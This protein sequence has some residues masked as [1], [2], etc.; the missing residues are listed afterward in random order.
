MSA[1][2]IRIIQMNQDKE[3]LGMSNYIRIFI[4]KVVVGVMAILTLSS[5]STYSS[6]F[7]CSDARGLPCEML[8]I[9]DKKIDSGEIDKVYR[10]SCNGKKCEEL[11]LQED[12]AMP[13][14]GP[15]RAKAASSYEEVEI[16]IE[17]DDN[18]PAS[19]QEH[20]N[21]EGAKCT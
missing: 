4:Q 6:K 19:A 3:F 1:K 16:I 11:V 18:S 8:R 21:L 20:K 10:K 12:V 15:I 2:E 7:A 17:E 9:V 14:T 5:C 13:R